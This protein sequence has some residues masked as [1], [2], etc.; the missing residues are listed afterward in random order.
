MWLLRVTT[1]NL[2]DDSSRDGG[3]WVRLGDRERL[4]GVAFPDAY[5]VLLG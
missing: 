5:V 4:A 3:R 1:P 2:P